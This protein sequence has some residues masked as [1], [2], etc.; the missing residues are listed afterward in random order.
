MDEPDDAL[1][2]GSRSTIRR[3]GTFRKA[4]S[5]PSISAFQRSTCA[6]A[7]RQAAPAGSRP[8]DGPCGP[9]RWE[10]ELYIFEPIHRGTRGVTAEKHVASRQ[11]DRARHEV[12][13]VGR[14]QPALA[15]IDVLV[16]LRRIAGRQAV[17]PRRH[18]VPFR[19]HGVGAILDHL[20]QARASQTAIRRSMSQI[21]PRMWLSSRTRAP[22]A[23]PWPPDR[24]C[25]WSAPRSSRRRP[26]PRRRWRSRP[27]PGP[28]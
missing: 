24:R 27:A 8:A 6:S 20:N 18:A 11:N 9:T 5:R 26:V 3:P 19:T 17:P 28:G 2:G 15:R 10:S 22:L 16:G 12:R 7:G 13:I 1:S 4:R 23:P 25:R 14:D 21:W